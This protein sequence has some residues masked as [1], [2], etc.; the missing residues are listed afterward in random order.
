MLQACMQ[1]NFSKNAEN[2]D[3]VQGKTFEKFPCILENSV[4]MSL[5][6]E[7]KVPASFEI[8][9]KSASGLPGNSMSKKSR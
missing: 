1:V 9:E 7:K 3:C 5:R 6:F 2:S 8:I 4:S